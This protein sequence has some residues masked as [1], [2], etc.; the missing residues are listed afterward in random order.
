MDKLASL[1][2]FVAVAD[3]GSFAEAARELGL[4][5][6][7]VNRQ[8]V[9]MEDQLGVQ[10]FNR[11][12]RSVSLTPGGDNFYKRVRPLLIDLREAEMAVQSEHDEPQGEIRI[13]APLS[14]GVRH[15]SPALT[16]FMKL[17]PKISVQLILSDQFVDPV[18]E[19]FDVT[20]RIA[21]RRDNPS[22]IEHEIIE[23]RRVICAAPG[24]LHAHG[25]PA[26][27]DDLANQPCLHYG[28][29]PTGGIWR[30]TKNDNS[31]DVRVQGALCSNNADVLNDAA[32]AGL[33][34]ALLPVFIAG[35]DL[36]AGRLVAVLP[37]YQAPKIYLS[38]VYPPNR[39]LSSRIRLFVKFIQDWFALSDF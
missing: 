30:L 8:V 23:A 34:I 25:V 13:N 20:M 33:G 22:L 18:A 39:H 2:A 19:G 26:V 29:L 24:F 16:E 11:T 21:S 31:Y 37:E 32:V 35:D 15:L 36:K 5:R 4:S 17:Y 9:Q 6:S 38:L 28:N 12:T 3:K 14:F 1:S 27:P 7:Q 10:L